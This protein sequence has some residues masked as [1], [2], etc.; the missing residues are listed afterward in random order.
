[1][2]TFTLLF[3]MLLLSAGAH[4]QT[5][6]TFEDLTLPGADTFYVNLTASGTDVG[7]SDGLARFPCVYD[8]AGGYTTWNYFAYSNKTDSIT[9]GYTNQYAAKPDM[10]YGGSSKYAIA[11]CANPANYLDNTVKVY[12]TG[13]AMG[14]QVSGF[15]V[16]NSTYAYNSMA[17]GYPAE[18]PAK[19]FDS[20][21]WFL[22]TVKGYL[23]GTFTTDSVNYYLADY[24][25][26]DSASRY[27]VKTWNWV[28]LTS[29]GSVDSLQFHLTS[30]DT[31]G[32]FGMNTPAYFCID[33]FTT[34]ETEAV[35]NIATAYAVKVYPNP[36]TDM[37]YADVADNTVQQIIVSDMAGNI[38]GSYP[39]Q[40]HTA[41]NTSLLSSGCYMLRL[42]GDG[43]SA[44]VKFVKQY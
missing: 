35:K 21:D 15:Y 34:N 39:A 6:A 19:K 30:S 32:G 20:G 10:G 44:S 17:P 3:S 4:A 27:V 14:K 5:V 38:V 7:F 9:N 11:Y 8:T 36:A 42:D 23:G 22:L 16:A 29:L 40:K 24:R 13:A 26:A 43:K 1:M 2:R 18:Y 37:L 41:I 12:L 25:S 33:N 28:D 31:A